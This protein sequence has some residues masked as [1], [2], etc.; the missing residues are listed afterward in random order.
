MKVSFGLEVVFSNDRNRPGDDEEDDVEYTQHYFREE[1]PHVFT[2][3][4]KEFIRQAIK[5][6]FERI[7][8]QMDEWAENG[9]GRVVERISHAYVNA[10]CYEPLRP[11]SFIDIPEKLKSKKAIINVVNKDEEC[12]KWSLRAAL[13]HAP[14]GKNPK[15]PSNYP[16]DDG[17]DYKGI[18]FPTPVK[19]IDK[20]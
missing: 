7:D 3:N 10:A 19:Q 11:A 1:E 8:S 6:F 12:L 14:C 17:I 18:D 15:R 13:Y 20:L 9:S 5:G 16:V 2:R 4:S